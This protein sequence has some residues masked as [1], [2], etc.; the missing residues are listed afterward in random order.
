MENILIICDI[1]LKYRR[2]RVSESAKPGEIT[3]EKMKNCF[4]KVRYEN[5]VS[6]NG[7]TFVTLSNVLTFQEYLNFKKFLVR[8]FV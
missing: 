4:R 3:D 5:D 1:A 2:L 6:K 8:G 7:V